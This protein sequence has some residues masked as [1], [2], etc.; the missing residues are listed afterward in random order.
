MAIVLDYY[1]ARVTPSP[2]FYSA[3]L[4]NRNI[5]LSSLRFLALRFTEDVDEDVRV[6]AFM[7]ISS[8]NGQAQTLDLG[9]FRVAFTDVSTTALAAALSTIDEGN[10][11]EEVTFGSSVITG[12][13]F[14]NYITGIQS[15]LTS[16]ELNELISRVPTADAVTTTTVRQLASGTQ[17]AAPASGS[18][19]YAL[20]VIRATGAVAR[21]TNQASAFCAG[22]FQTVAP[23]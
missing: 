5:R 16:D 22:V 11:E 6:Q 17:L 13:P 10:Y 8:V 1:A 21:A 3:G 20:P 2:I 15:G 12:L 19:W 23:A 14:S 18:N 9:K 4:G 7:E